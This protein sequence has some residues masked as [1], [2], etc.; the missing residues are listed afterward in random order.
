MPP[1]SGGGAL[2]DRGRLPA[3]HERQGAYPHGGAGEDHGG[4]GGAR[5]GGTPSGFLS[6]EGRRLVALVQGQPMGLDAL[7][8]RGARLCPEG[9]A[10]AW[11]FSQLAKAEL[12][13]VIRRFPD[14]T[15]GPDGQAA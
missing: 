11:V 1:G 6:E 15:Y 3:F 10:R 9:D 13:G 12:A 14:G 2:P 8:D 4:Y 7:L 5:G